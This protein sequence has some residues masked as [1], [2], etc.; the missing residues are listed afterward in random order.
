M[1]Y[2]Y[3]IKIGDTIC[4]FKEENR[5]GFVV[6]EGKPFELFVM[7]PNQKEI[8]Y[9]IELQYVHCTIVLFEKSYL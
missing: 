1:S 8:F 4:R 6:N 2:N 5:K 3:S 9:A 7:R